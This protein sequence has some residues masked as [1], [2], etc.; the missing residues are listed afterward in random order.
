[1]NKTAEP[2]NSVTRL[3]IPLIGDINNRRFLTAV[4]AGVLGGA[5]VSSAANL[6]RQF[7]MMRK[8][9][10]EETDA[11][12]IVLNI[13]QKEASARS[14]QGASFESAKAAKPGETKPAVTKPNGSTQSRDVGRYGVN[15]GGYKADRDVTKCAEG[16]PGPN[17]VGTV[18]ANALG[19]T[20]GGLLSYE[21]VS[22]LFDR[23]NERRLKKKLEAAQQA[24]ID[25]MT[26]ASKRAEAVMRIIGP[27]ERAICKSAETKEAGLF[28]WMSDS[29]PDSATNAIRYPAAAYILALLAGTGASA[30]VTKKVMDREF[31]EEKLKSDINKPTRIL[32]KTVEGKPQVIE[33][34]GKQEKAA[35][36][37]TCAAITA[38]LPIYMDVVEGQPSR[39]LAAPYVKIAKANGVDARGLMSLAAKSFPSAYTAVLKDPKAVWEILKGTGFGLNF[40]KLRAAQILRNARPDTYRRAV[41]AAI[42]SHFAGSPNDGLVRRAWTGIQKAVAKGIASTDTGRDW[43]VNRALSPK[44]AASDDLLRA[45]YI[46]SSVFKD[47][48]AVKDEDP[49]EEVDA[50]AVLAKVRDR[51]KDRRKVQVQAADPNAAAF[52]TKNKAAIQKLLA[53][54]NSQG[55]I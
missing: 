32:F 50:K 41:D 26:G 18:V 46:T 38:L 12:T 19:M 1:M 36:A 55:T 2:S 43:M 9:D 24:Y 45:G 23:M 44:T 28:N 53:R 30:Y 16:N 8:K 14:S 47:P 5:G 52:V 39:T 34:D 48:D 25:A 4:M 3:P 51:L 7:R 49:E 35:S 31:P 40:S 11:D 15:I 10:K 6:L 54:M 20:A 21:V 17:S 37:D 22:R 27:V 33:D 29:L 13:P 42:D